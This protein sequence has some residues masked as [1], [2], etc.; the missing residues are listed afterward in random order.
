[1]DTSYI[2]GK[3]T[4]NLLSSL[5]EME[6]GLIKERV[7]DTL[8]VKKENNKVYSPTP[9]GFDRVGDRL[10]PNEV[11]QRMVKKVLM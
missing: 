4:I 8:R 5:Y 7:S 9:Y 6:L 10:V 11:E 3:F 2:Y 1:M